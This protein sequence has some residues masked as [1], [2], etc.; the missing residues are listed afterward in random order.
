VVIWT[1]AYYVISI[2]FI[3]CGAAVGLRLTRELHPILRILS[4][5][6]ITAVTALLWPIPIHGGITMIGGILLEEFSSRRKQTPERPALPSGSDAH[7]RSGR[8]AGRMEIRSEIS[9]ADRWHAVVL[10]RNRRAWLDPSS[11]LLWSDSQRLTGSSRLHRIDAAKRLC[12]EL[13]PAGYW[14]LPTEAEQAL[15]WNTAT[16]S[17]LPGSE[18]SEVSYIVDDSLGMELP[19][20]RVRGHGN[21]ESA[22]PPGA[23][24]RCVA[25]GPGAPPGGFIRRDID[26]ELWNR[27]Q[28]SKINPA[29]P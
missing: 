2:A 24:I 10:G 11:G 18:I 22:V 5:L 8:F 26:L 3:L 12:T 25:L 29:R 4:S 23:T 21:N 7:F 17:G 14:A 28:T 1:L 13:E 27:Y 6:S 15:L 16:R 19:V 20:F 9:T